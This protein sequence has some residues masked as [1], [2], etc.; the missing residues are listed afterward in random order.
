MSHLERVSEERS[1]PEAYTPRHL[2]EKILT[3]YT[4]KVE[5]LVVKRP[6]RLSYTYAMRNPPSNSDAIT[7]EIA[8]DGSGCMVTF[9]QS[10]EDIASE[11]RE[12]PPGGTSGSETG[13]QLA[14]DLMAAG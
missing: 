1:P 13:W 4:A 2:A 7:V 14:F 8:P 9:V 10:G 12:L 3:Q 5:Y 11:L 6:W